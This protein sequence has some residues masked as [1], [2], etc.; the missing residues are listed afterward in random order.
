MNSLY[1]YVIR[2]EANPLAGIIYD[3][4]YVKKAAGRNWVNEFAEWLRHKDKF[5]F[6]GYVS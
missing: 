6:C 3:F 2:W 5:F 4:E 1:I